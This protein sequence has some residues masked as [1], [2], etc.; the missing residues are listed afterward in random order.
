MPTY[1][2][3]QKALN[4]LLT[5]LKNL[6]C[7]YVIVDNEGTTHTHGDALKK[8]GHAKKG[9]RYGFGVLRD[10]YGPWIKDLQPGDSAE[11]PCDKFDV[12]AVQAGVANMAS[13]M[14]GSGSFMTSRNKEKN[15]LEVIRIL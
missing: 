2:L 5:G 1:S 6:G 10:Y 3:R 4:N 14:W 9:S 8:K 7:S 12:I 15:S 11:I 13:D